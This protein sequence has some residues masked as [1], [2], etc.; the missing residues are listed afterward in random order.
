[1]LK[2]TDLLLWKIKNIKKNQREKMELTRQI[3]SVKLK[4]SNLVENSLSSALF[5]A[6]NGPRDPWAGHEANLEIYGKTPIPK[7]GSYTT[8]FEGLVEPG[9]IERLKI[10][11]TTMGSKG[12]VFILLHGVPM[13]R[14][15]K[16]GLMKRMCKFCRVAAFDLLGMGESSQPLDFPWSWELHAMYVPGLVKDILASFGLPGNTKVFFQS[17]DWGSG[18]GAKLAESDW[19]NTHC[20]AHLFLDPVAFS[21]Y[22]ISEIGTLGRASQLP[23]VPGAKNPEFN[24]A[25]GAFDQTIAQIEKSMQQ[26]RSATNQWQQRDDLFPYVE[27]D[28]ERNDSAKVK[29]RNGVERLQKLMDIETPYVYTPLTRHLRMWNIRVLAQQSAYLRPASLQP[30]DAVKN[31][32]G[33]QYDRVKNNVQVLFAKNDRMMPALQIYHFKYAMVNARVSV[34]LIPDADHFAEKDQPD[35]IAESYLNYI[36]EVLGVGALAQPFLGLTGV[37]KGD[38]KFRHKKLLKMYY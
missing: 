32:Q 4:G 7:H 33:I 6:Y 9:K 27:T 36:E 30:Y 24:M 28:Y 18:V 19:G 2:P 37:F 13:N 31:P 21:G 23:F 17:D 16:I 25:M 34:G 1:M 12:P 14:R 8:R 11:Y 3:N 26:S 20:H 22:F 10:K 35:W 38:E 15:M 5:E 29:G